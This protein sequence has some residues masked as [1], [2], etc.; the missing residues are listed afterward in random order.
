MRT[1]IATL[2][3]AL[4]LA[5]PACDGGPGAVDDPDAA[6]TGDVTSPYEADNFV[7]EDTVVDDDAPPAVFPGHPCEDDDQCSTGLCWG[8]VTTKGHFQDK[9]CQ[10]RCVPLEDFSRYCDSDVDCCAGHCCLGCG[11]REGLC[12]PD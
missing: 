11:P 8:A 10:L 2:L 7:A 3:L 9:L 6:V 1:L 4:T 5:A 12:V